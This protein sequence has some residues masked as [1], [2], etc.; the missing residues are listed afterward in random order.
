MLMLG[1]VAL[2]LAGCGDSSEEESTTPG[3]GLSEA[4]RALEPP[5]DTTDGIELSWDDLVP[6]D[7]QPET[8]M[9]E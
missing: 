9:E 5:G 3:S 2:L 4:E 7:W 6:A 1:L 8:L